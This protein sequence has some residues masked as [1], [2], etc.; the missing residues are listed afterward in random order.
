M[1][2]F[3]DLPNFLATK[4][5]QETVNGYFNHTLSNTSHQS[6][7]FKKSLAEHFGCFT[8]S[9]NE[10]YVT[11][12]TASTHWPD[13]R[14]CVEELIQGLQPLSD[15]VNNY[16]EVTYSLLYAKMKS[17]ILVPTFPNLLEPFLL[18]ALTLT[19][20]ANFTGI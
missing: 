3:F 20:F 17:L 13:H 11:T 15:E 5:A 6:P 10:P 1:I 14:N 7:Q 2:D 9:N 12:N 19:Q 16:L 18:L 8:D 4:T